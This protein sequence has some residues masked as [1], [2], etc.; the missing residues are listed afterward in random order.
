MKNIIQY[1]YYRLTRFYKNTFHIEDSPGFL[2]QSCYDWG[3]QVLMAAV[4]FYLLSIETIVLRCLGIQLK[5]IYVLL[6]MLP[7][8]LLHVF[9][10]D[11]FG[12]EKERYK[13]LEKKYKDDKY[14]LIKGVLVGLFVGLSLPCFIIA[15]FLK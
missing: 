7:F 12:D 13:A 15:T 6:T 5:I 4:C 1:I 11:I 14:N 8:F 2:I 9:S 10:E 3:S